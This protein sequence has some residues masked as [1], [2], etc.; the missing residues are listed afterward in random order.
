MPPLC[1][2]RCRAA[3]VGLF[4]CRLLGGNDRCRWVLPFFLSAAC[5]G[6]A[7]SRWVLPFVT[8]RKRK[9]PPFRRGGRRPGLRPWTR[10]CG[11]LT[12]AY[13]G[14][15]GPEQGMDLEI[16]A[17]EPPLC[18]GR[19]R[20]A[21]VGLET[22]PDFPLPGNAVKSP[23]PQ[24]PSAP[25]P[26]AQGSHYQLLPGK[27]GRTPT[28]QG[29]S[30]NHWPLFAAALFRKQRCALLFCPG[31]IAARAKKSPHRAGAGQ[32]Q[33]CF[34][35]SFPRPDGRAGPRR[36][37]YTGCPGHGR[38]CRSRGGSCR[39]LPPTADGRG[40]GGYTPQSRSHGKRAGSR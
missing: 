21:A 30:P 25:A 28:G 33:R 1:K 17:G 3:A 22:M 20:A 35:S 34:T 23:T 14:P 40:R 10:R 38:T 39:G 15:G 5:G 31:G 26:L 37:A 9:V 32:K 27:G 29:F 24:S 18:K 11:H 13:S 6:T 16:L 12:T 19:C 2:G 7:A 4:C 36:P 8:K